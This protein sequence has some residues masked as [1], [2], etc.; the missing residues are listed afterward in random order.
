MQCDKLAIACEFLDIT[1]HYSK[2]FWQKS[3]TFTLRTEPVLL[4]R[5]SHMRNDFSPLT[6]SFFDAMYR[7][8]TEAKTISLTIR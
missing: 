5:H 4:L 1:L 6:I 7:I 8:T 2:G 3:S